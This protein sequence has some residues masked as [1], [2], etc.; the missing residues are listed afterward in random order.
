MLLNPDR[1]YSKHSQLAR[2]RRAPSPLNAIATF[3]AGLVDEADSRGYNF[4]RDKI[5]SPTD[6]VAQI[7]VTVGQLQYEWSH[8]GAK[9]AHRSPS[10]AA[11][12]D[13]VLLPK[14]HPMFTTVEGPIAT[15]ER[16]I[17]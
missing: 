17:R 15:W 3:L 5:T 16:P 1:G 7:E 4:A 11:R 6:N 9:L 13:Q 14:T 8:L 10:I 2:F 12:W